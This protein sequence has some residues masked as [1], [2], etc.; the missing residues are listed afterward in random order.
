MMRITVVI[1]EKVKMCRTN[2]KFEK[3]ENTVYLYVHCVRMS[4][5]MI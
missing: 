5:M 1:S 2:C 3:F 4:E